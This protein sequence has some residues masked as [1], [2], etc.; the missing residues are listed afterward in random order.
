MN[1]LVSG[2][3]HEKAGTD[4]S[5][6]RNNERKT[7]KWIS[8][9]FIHQLLEPFSNF[10][11]N[12]RPIQAG[13][14]KPQ[15]K[16]LDQCHHICHGKKSPHFKHYQWSGDKKW[17]AVEHREFCRKLTEYLKGYNWFAEGTC[18]SSP[19]V[20][21]CA[22]TEQRWFTQQFLVLAKVFSHTVVVI[23][24]SFQKQNSTW[25]GK[26]S[27]LCVSDTNCGLKYINICRNDQARREATGF[28]QRRTLLS[29]NTW[30]QTEGEEKEKLFLIEREATKCFHTNTMKTHIES[31][32]EK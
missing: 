11:A 26:M 31:H 13:L 20:I 30:M 3:N 22:L 24:N 5:N 27:C 7:T 12:R 28:T 1:L 23:I 8:S 6:P 29:S 10:Q 9:F 4:K 16:S 21:L 14:W 2:G 17:L 15:L 19:W 25:Y 32:P 18:S